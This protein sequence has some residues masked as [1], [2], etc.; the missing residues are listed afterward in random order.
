MSYSDIT[1]FDLRSKFGIKDTTTQLFDTVKPV[2]PS[3]WLKETLALTSR[4]PVKRQS[5]NY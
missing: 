5:Q 1:L 4:I 2:Q 3:V